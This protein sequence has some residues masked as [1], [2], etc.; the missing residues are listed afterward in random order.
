MADEQ[1]GDTGRLLPAVV[2]LCADV[3]TSE[4]P[5][6]IVSF[7]QEASRCAT[8]VL[9]LIV[10]CR[11][12]WIMLCM[13]LAVAL[14]ETSVTAQ[15]L[16]PALAHFCSAKQCISHHNFSRRCLIFAFHQRVLTLCAHRRLLALAWPI[17]LLNLLNF[18]GG[19]MPLAFVGHLDPFSLSVAVLATSFFNVSGYCIIVGTAAALETLCGQVRVF[20]VACTR[21][22]VAARACT[23]ALQAIVCCSSS[24]RPL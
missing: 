3:S 22:Q 19:I 11:L 9:G 10:L 5:G 15:R 17:S 12:A 14:S 24:R 6:G 13:P 1:A 4:Q 16:P 2:A 18:V 23:P 20:I 21:H 8:H 7:R